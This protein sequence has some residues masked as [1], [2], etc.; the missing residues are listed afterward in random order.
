MSLRLQA[1]GDPGRIEVGLVMVNADEAGAQ[2]KGYGL[3]TFEPN[4]QRAREAWSLSCGDRINLTG[5]EVR[6]G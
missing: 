1:T 2:C 3:A 4:H 6:A 5:I